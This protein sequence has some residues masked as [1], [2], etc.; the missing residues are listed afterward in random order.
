MSS[1][2][3]LSA[4]NL[5]AFEFKSSVITVPV[6]NIYTTDINVLSLQL[7]EKVKQAPEFFKNSSVL[8]DLQN[9][10]DQ[11][12]NLSLLVDAIHNVEILPI[13]IRGGSE[14]HKKLAHQLQLPSFN[15]ARSSAEKP[16]IKET[17]EPTVAESAEP[18][19]NNIENT[20][21]TQP[22]R[23][24]QRVYAK[25]DLVITS[26]VSAGAEVIAEGNIHIYGALRG[27]ALAG[28]L[29]DETARIFCSDLQAELISIAGNYRISEDIDQS[30]KKVPVQI[31]LNEQALIIQ[32]T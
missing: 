24:G 16:V 17:P 3:S 5:P 15:N 9:I 27:R 14:D 7:R 30:Y 23:S 20:L 4:Q 1:I 12:L 19:L 21:I 32:N 10:Q 18:V 8:I 31:Y 28:V 6:L 11:E 25:G 29:G 26:H 22:V 2:P 13:G